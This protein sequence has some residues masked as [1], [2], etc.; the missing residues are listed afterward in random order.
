MADVGMF[1]TL[2]PKYLSH[3]YICQALKRAAYGVSD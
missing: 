2:S 1:V 3:S